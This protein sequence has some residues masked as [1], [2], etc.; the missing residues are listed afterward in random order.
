[1]WGFWWEKKELVTG[2]WSCYFISLVSFFY[3]FVMIIFL[4]QHLKCG[5]ESVWIT[6]CVYK[7]TDS[8]TDSVERL[9]SRTFSCCL[10]WFSLLR[11]S[12]IDADTNNKLKKWG[13]TYGGMREV[14][15][16]DVLLKEH[17][18]NLPT[19]RWLRPNVTLL[20]VQFSCFAEVC[21]HLSFNAFVLKVDCFQI[22]S[23]F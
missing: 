3:Y 14:K 12:L 5:V 11:D 7:Q 10:I 1:M 4:Q 13:S 16:R 23:S 21:V 2:F 15:S 22:H 6:I 17:C 8:H 19:T 18:R 9:L 20:R